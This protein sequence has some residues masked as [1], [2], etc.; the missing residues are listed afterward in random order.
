MRSGGFAWWD[1]H[2]RAWRRARWLFVLAAAVVAVYAA[3]LVIVVGVVLRA[4]GIGPWTDID[5][6][7]EDLGWLDLVGLGVRLCLVSAAAI[8]LVGWRGLPRI[9]LRYARARP[10]AGVEAHDVEAAAASLAVAYGIPTPRVWII[11]D[12]APNG[13]A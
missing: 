2:S 7:F 10:P 11:E 13:L 4:A 6:W 9:S 1:V 3:G 8:I 5:A 12:P